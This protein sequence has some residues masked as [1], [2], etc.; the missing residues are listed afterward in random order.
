M[1]GTVDW[2][3]LTERLV[4]EAERRMRHLRRVLDDITGGDKL[5]ELP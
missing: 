4:E 2:Q 1:S 5:C 3:H